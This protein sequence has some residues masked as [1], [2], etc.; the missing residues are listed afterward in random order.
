MPMMVTSG[1][2]MKCSFGVAPST[3]NVLPTNKVSGPAPVASIAASA[4]EVTAGS[5]TLQVKLLMHR[6]AA[7]VGNIYA[8]ALG[9]VTAIPRP[10]AY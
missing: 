2:M 10:T 6:Y 4:V 8:S 3:L 1:A 7:F 9:S 5:G